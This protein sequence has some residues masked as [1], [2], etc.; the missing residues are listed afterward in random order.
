MSDLEGYCAEVVANAE[1]ASSTISDMSQF[2]LRRLL[3]RNVLPV[4]L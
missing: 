4:V 3:R 2:F 1:V